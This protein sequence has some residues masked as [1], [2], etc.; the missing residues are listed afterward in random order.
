MHTLR[1]TSA[2]APAPCPVTVQAIMFLMAQWLVLFPTIHLSPTNK[3]LIFGR[4]VQPYGTWKYLPV[5]GR[6]RML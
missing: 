1:D 2:A 3:F 6:M 5:V 4:T